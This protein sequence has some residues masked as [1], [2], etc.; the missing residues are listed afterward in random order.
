MTITHRMSKTPT[1]TSWYKMKGRCLNKRGHNYKYYGGRGIKICKRWEIFE[2]FY[3]DMGDRSVGTSLDRI[4]N[5]KGYCKENCR[6]ATQQE[7]VSNMRRNVKYRG[8]TASAA[9]RRLGGSD[10]IV[11]IRVG[12]LGWSK[13][14]A[15][16]TPVKSYKGKT[17]IISQASRTKDA[18]Q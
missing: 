15:F 10:T 7:Q 12:V 16:T 3:K 18:T 8:E 4:D 5:D 13:E 9:S 1:Y 14:K 17:S 6:W 2:N 11:A